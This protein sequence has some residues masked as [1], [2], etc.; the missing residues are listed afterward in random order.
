MPEEVVARSELAFAEGLR[1]VAGGQQALAGSVPLWS[2]L[3]DAWVL[4][5]GRELGAVAAYAGGRRG[6]IWNVWAGGCDF[7]G[8]R[9]SLPPA[10]EG[11]VRGR[12]GVHGE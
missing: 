6:G 11:L 5:K 7:L 12:D 3:C 9:V 1:H 2:S 8:G 10:L 4:Q